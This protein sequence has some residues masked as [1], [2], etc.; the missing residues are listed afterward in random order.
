MFSGYCNIPGTLI[1][2][3][4]S[5]HKPNTSESDIYS[6]GIFTETLPKK[7][8][9]GLYVYKKRKQCS[10]WKVEKVK[11][12]NMYNEHVEKHTDGQTALLGPSTSMKEMSLMGLSGR[13]QQP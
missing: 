5:A 2:F 7:K 11:L 6:K 13:S 1:L 8:T 3:H 4:A 9:Q 10:T 12:M